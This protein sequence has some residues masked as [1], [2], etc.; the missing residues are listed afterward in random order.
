MLMQGFISFAR[1]LS[2]LARSGFK[3]G[4]KAA[5]H[6]CVFRARASPH[7]PKSFNR[8]LP[9]KYIISKRILKTISRRSLFISKVVPWH[10]NSI[11][12]FLA[13]EIQ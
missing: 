13:I 5:L 4:N 8:S 10:F 6:S 9:L 1:K 7:S 12:S 3:P 11:L 2:A